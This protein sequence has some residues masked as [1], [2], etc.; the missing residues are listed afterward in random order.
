MPGR[1]FV[2][3]NSVLRESVSIFQRRMTT[4][5]RGYPEE[6]AIAITRR[7]ANVFRS[8]QV[9]VNGRLA[10]LRETCTFG[11]PGCGRLL[12]KATGEPGDTFAQKLQHPKR[13]VR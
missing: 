10:L 11:A 5:E 2:A 4:E 1:E 12:P 7:V 8:N 9:R 6:T 3:Q 13:S